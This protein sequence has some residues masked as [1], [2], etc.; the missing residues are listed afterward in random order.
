MNARLNAKLIDKTLLVKKASEYEKELRFDRQRLSL[1]EDPTLDQQLE[2]IEGLQMTTKDQFVL[3][4]LKEAGFDT[5]RKVLGASPEELKK[6][7]SIT[8][9]MIE[10][11]VDKIRKKKV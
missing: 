4:S 7:T 1:S 9:D 3:E 11:I 2:E 8:Q 10:E 6:I 5:L